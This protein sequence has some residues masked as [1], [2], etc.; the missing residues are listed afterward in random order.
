MLGKLL[1]LTEEMTTTKIAQTILS[2]QKIHCLFSLN[3]VQRKSEHVKKGE[4]KMLGI[5]LF[6]GQEC[7]SLKKRVLHYNYDFTFCYETVDLTQKELKH[8]VRLSTTS[9]FIKVKVCFDD[10]LLPSDAL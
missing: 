10:I 3:K 9:I 4:K 8:L 7:C 5:G 2:L 6:I 1:R